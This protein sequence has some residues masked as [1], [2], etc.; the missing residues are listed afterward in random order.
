G[1]FCVFS[2]NGILQHFKTQICIAM[3]IPTKRPQLDPVD[4]CNT[5]RKNLVSP[6]SITP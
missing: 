3:A 2:C 5:N 1:S 4:A 6:G